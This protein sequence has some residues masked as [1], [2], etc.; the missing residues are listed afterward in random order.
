MSGQKRTFRTRQQSGDIEMRPDGWDR[1][2]RAVNAAAKSG[3]KPR[4]AE[5]I[6]KKTK[7]RTRVKK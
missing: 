3:P 5:A 6:K 1:F 4:P 2:R 7:S